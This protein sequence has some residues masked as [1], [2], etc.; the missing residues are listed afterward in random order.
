MNLLAFAQSGGLLIVPSCW[1][2][3]ASSTS[4]LD[5]RYRLRNHGS[6]WVAVAQA[7]W[8]DPYLLAEEIH[9]LV[10]RRND[11][12]RL[13]NGF[14]MSLYS[15]ISPDRQHT[16]V[17]LINSDGRARRSPV[18]LWVKQPFRRARF[19][20]LGADEAVALSPAAE[21]QG[22]E[23]ALPSFGVYAAVELEA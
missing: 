7:E 16:V 10:S 23:L 12:F 14:S 17:H 5:G 11:P 18:S 13:G 15:T 6:G 21:R 1:T 19:W 22:K 20:Q 4:H 9:L 3:L 8:R 2:E